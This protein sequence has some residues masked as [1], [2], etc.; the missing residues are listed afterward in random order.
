[1]EGGTVRRFRC[2]HDKTVENTVK[3]RI[4]NR[5]TGAEYGYD[6]CRTCI[7]QHKKEDKALFTKEEKRLIYQLYAVPRRLAGAKE[8]L[9]KWE[10]EARDLGLHDLITVDLNPGLDHIANFLNALDTEGMTVNEVRSAIY[11]ECV[12][13]TNFINPKKKEK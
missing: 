10:K 11:A 7:N 2:G 13:P 4:K 3:Q 8:R 9:Q 1:M 12:N 6:R 5:K